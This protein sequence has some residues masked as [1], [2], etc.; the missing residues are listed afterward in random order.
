MNEFLQWFSMGG[1]ANYV[2]PA[3]GLVSLTLVIIIVSV[4]N[5]RKRTHRKLQ[6]WFKS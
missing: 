5:Q 4:K 6:Q 3:Y 2:W 1:Y